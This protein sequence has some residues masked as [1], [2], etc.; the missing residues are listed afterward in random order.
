MATLS[1][2]ST[3]TGWQ[4]NLTIA[5]PHKKRPR[6]STIFS[7]CTPTATSNYTPVPSLLVWSV[8]RNFWLSSAIQT[9][10]LRILSSIT[11]RRPQPYTTHRAHRPFNPR[12]TFLE[13]SL[14]TFIFALYF[15]N[16][17]ITSSLSISLSS[18]IQ[19]KIRISCFLLPLGRG[20]LKK[21][22]ILTNKF[23][24]KSSSHSS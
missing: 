6:S 23:N 16:I 5:S 9:I 20:L 1:I 14:K 21:A 18:F 3:G 7:R 11:G 2:S 19:L 13:N 17:F 8:I 15:F 12:L 24:K 22:F 10:G 4:I